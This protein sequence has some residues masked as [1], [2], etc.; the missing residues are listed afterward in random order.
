[1]H[2][3]GGITHCILPRARTPS[4]DTRFADIAIPRL[5]GKLRA[6]GSTMLVAKVFGGAAVLPS[7]NSLTV[8]DSNIRAA[9]AIL[10]TH[11]IEIVAQRT[12]G[13]NGVVLLFSTANGAVKLREIKPAMAEALVNV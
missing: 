4:D 8:G 11:H 3:Y 12:G 13:D 9:I 10:Q 5:A 1:V 6:L 2:G 7:G